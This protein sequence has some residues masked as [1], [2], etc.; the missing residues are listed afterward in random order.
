M[1]LQFNAATV[2]PTQGPE[3]W[4]LADYPLEITKEEVKA[5]KDDA[6]STYLELTLT[7]LDGQFK[8]KTHPY[9]LNLWNS[10]QESQRIAYQ[11]LSALCHAIGRI[12][13]ADTS[14]LIGGRLIG[15]IGPQ[16]NDARYSE[17]KRVKDMN[18]NEP[19]RA[20]HAPATAA[21]APSYGAAPT[22][23]YAQPGPAPTAAA[24]AQPQGGWQAPAPAAAPGWGTTTAA[25]A[26]APPPPPPATEQLSPDGK[27][28]LVNNAWVPNEPPP[29]PP[30]APAAG[31]WQP[32]AGAPTQAAPPPPPPTATGWQPNADPNAQPAAAPWGKPQQ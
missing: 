14:H 31:G 27:W 1:Q 29:P 30:P 18:G 15:V 11:Q 20:S 8:G 23:A 4:P 13:I 16:K 17:V 7:C 25:A 6:S 22:P 2:D 28:K 3:V 32:P 5:V 12:Q 19:G 26:P 24:P 9:R 21:P 10:N